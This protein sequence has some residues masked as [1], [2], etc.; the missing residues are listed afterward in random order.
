[1]VGGAD[2]SRI[3]VTCFTYSSLRHGAANQGLPKLSMVGVR[4]MKVIFVYYL[5]KPS[6]R[7]WASQG[8]PEPSTVGVGLKISIIEMRLKVE[9]RWHYSYYSTSLESRHSSVSYFRVNMRP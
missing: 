2:E 1:M 7:L 9:I 4:L 6:T 8:L 3:R 5:F